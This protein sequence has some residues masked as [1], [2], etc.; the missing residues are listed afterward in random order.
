MNTAKVNFPANYTGA[1]TI[2]FENLNGNSFAD[3]EFSG[4]VTSPHVVPEFSQ[5]SLMVI[6]SIIMIALIP[7][8]NLFK[9]TFIK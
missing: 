3:S 6:L 5:V 7:K 4:V 8:S 1:I 2:A 9:V